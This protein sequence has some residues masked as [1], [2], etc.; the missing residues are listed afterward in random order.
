MMAMESLENC[1]LLSAAISFD[2]LTVNGTSGNDIV[3]RKAAT[4]L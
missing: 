2:M 4:P 3:A 1:Q